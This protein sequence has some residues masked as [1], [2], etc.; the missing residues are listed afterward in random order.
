MTD[1]GISTSS[2]YEPY[3]TGLKDDIFIKVR[4]MLMLGL[5]LR[6]LDMPLAYAFLFLYHWQCY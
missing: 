2:N 4:L 1:C 3:L 6:Y 5:F